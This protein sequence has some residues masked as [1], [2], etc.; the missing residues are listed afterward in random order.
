MNRLQL[1]TLLLIISLSAQSQIVNE[2][3]LKIQPGTDVYFVNDYINKSGANLLNDGNLHFE[4]DLTNNGIVGATTAAT[5]TT[6]F[7][8]TIDATQHIY[9][10][11]DTNIVFFNNLTV[12]NVES[13]HESLEVKDNVGADNGVNFTV[14]KRLTIATDNKLRLFGNAQLI[15]NQSGVSINTGDGVILKDQDGALNTYR[16]NYW[17]SPVNTGNTYKVTE[18]LK[19]GTSPNTWSPTQTDFTSSLNGSTGP[20]KLSTRWFYK[21]IDGAQDPWNDAGWLSLFNIGTTTE[22][23]DAAIDPGQ[24]F[25]MKGPDATGGQFANQNY[26][27]QGQPNNGDISLA[28]GANKEYLVGN[29]YASALDMDQ[30]LLDNNAVLSGT[31]YFYEHWSDN[32]HYYSKYGAGYAT[33]NSSGGAEASLHPHFV[34]GAWDL[35]HPGT[36]G[37]GNVPQQF[38]PVG[39]GFIVRSGASAGNIVFNNGQR[40]FKTEGTSSFFFKSKSSEETTHTFSNG[41]TSRIYLGYTSPTERHRHLLLAVTDGAATNNFDNMYDGEM[42]DLGEND[43]YFTIGDIADLTEIPYVI[44][45]VGNYNVNARYPLTLKTKNAGEHSI[46]IDELQSFDHDVYIEDEKGQTHNLREAAYIINAPTGSNTYHLN[47][48]FKPAFD[49]AADISDLTD[50]IRSYYSN[51]ELIILNTESLKINGVQV[52]NTL[53]QLVYQTNDKNM[54]S[55]AKVSIPFVDF[56]HSAYVVKVQAATASVSFKFINY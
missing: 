13:N 1:L 42:I 7:D 38:I 54:L 20:L 40:A 51:E 39:Q 32:T 46:Q 14:D 21:Y 22:S 47:L 43:L 37:E 35:A 53:G 36:T 31:V 2:G 44:Q 19:D 29:P 10:T 50:S 28:I 23:V 30:F 34:G 6:F 33:Y 18:V 24:G 56:A 25:C 11:D 16:Y 27:F 17:S 26:T 3:F 8:S 9:V 15:Q 55:G 41:V 48:V 12:D 45:G 49:D 5:G 4:G 52:F